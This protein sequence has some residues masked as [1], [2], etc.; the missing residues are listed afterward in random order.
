MYIRFNQNV[1]YGHHNKCIFVINCS[2]RYCLMEFWC[3][4]LKTVTTQKHVRTK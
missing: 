2:L 3:E 4:L 1:H